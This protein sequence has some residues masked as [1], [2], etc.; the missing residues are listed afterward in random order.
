MSPKT[1]CILSF[2]FCLLISTSA[3]FA[4]AQ[5]DPVGEIVLAPSAGAFWG[6][7][8]KDGYVY[9]VTSW[10]EFAVV[11]ARSLSID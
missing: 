9:V 3:T 4:V 1:S 6:V 8:E 2:L 11:D 7:A 10:G 5:I